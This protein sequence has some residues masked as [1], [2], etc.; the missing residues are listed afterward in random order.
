M[1][2]KKP[3]QQNEYIITEEQ[4][5]FLRSAMFTDRERCASIMKEIQTR[6]IQP[7]CPTCAENAAYHQNES[8][9]G[10]CRR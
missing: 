5:K 9:R 6:P 10:H 1:S 8:E 4:I 2:D 7:H 3:Q